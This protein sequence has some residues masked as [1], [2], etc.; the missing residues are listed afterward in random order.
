MTARRLASCVAPFFATFANIAL[1]AAC[2]SDQAPAPNFNSIAGSSSQTTGGSGNTNAGT[3]G[4]SGSTGIAGTSSSTGGGSGVAGSTGS[5]G[6][7][8]TA[9]GTGTAGSSGTMHYNTPTGNS[10]ACGMGA[11]AGDS[12]T[13]FVE[14]D[15]DV[16][17]VD[18]AFIADNAPQ[19][20]A[21][22]TWTHRNYFVR[23]P[24]NYDP[25]KAYP[26]SMGG[27]G[28]GSGDGKS[29]NGGGLTALPNGQT[30]AIQVGL[31]Y[32]WHGHSCFAYNYVN[33]P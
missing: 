14:H 13:K 24:T 20:P 3:S 29:G 7:S 9:G 10:S 4:V 33:T 12:P 32:V 2:S 30:Q 22:W 16:T 23:L 11:P 25:T 17:G 5:A 1:F 19:S 28:C 27:G 8:G 15:V 21:P 18:P 6:T 26:V 31:S